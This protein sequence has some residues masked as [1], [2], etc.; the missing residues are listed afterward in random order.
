[1][2]IQER[3][4]REFKRREK[5]ILQA[6]LRLFDGDDWQLVTIERIAQEAEIG[7]GTVYLHFPSKEDIYGR[8][9][10]DFGRQLLAKLQKIDPELPV[11]DRLAAAIRVIFDAH[12]A[13]RR[14]QRIVDYCNRDD[15][16][17][18]LDEPTRA[19]LRRMDD[20]IIQLM[21]ATL[22]EGIEQ[23][24]FPK[25]PLESMLWGPHATLIGAVRMLSGNCGCIDPP[26][27]AEAEALIASVTNFMLAGLMT[28]GPQDS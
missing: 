26:G 27:P 16:R 23:G 5:E 18:R 3:K 4:E 22:Q 8:L 28:K 11:L 25:R 13:G 2:G 20:E 9:A 10:V 19:E 17:R 12:L 14:Y 7:K 24:I 6:A 1:M 21:M 15:F